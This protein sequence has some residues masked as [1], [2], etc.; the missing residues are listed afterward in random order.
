[1]ISVQEEELPDPTFGNETILK[2]I[3]T[4]SLVLWL[5]STILDS[6]DLYGNELD[7]NDAF[8]GLQE[9]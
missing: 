2:G 3:H 9:H 4:S 1:M 7:D 8:N 6:I 5:K